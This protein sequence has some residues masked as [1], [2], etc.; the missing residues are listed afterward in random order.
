[1]W[2]KTEDGVLV[3]THR[4]ECIYYNKEENETRGVLGDNWFVLAEGDIT[5]IIQDAI[6]KGCRYVGVVDCV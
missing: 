5:R 6:V 4:L 1:M 2:I 3:N